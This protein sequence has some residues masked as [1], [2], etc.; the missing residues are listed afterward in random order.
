[1]RRPFGNSIKHWLLPPSNASAASTAAPDEEVATH[2]ARLVL[3]LGLWRG[4][5][6][7]YSSGPEGRGGIS[8]KRLSRARITVTGRARYLELLLKWHGA[9]LYVCSRAHGLAVDVY[10][11]AKKQ[12]IV[13]NTGCTQSGK[14]PPFTAKELVGKDELC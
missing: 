3:A 6:S 2:R 8:R 9:P 4:K 11:E 13:N 10:G 12:T 5:K 1:M 7:R 14:R